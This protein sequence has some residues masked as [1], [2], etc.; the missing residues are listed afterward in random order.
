M[1]REGDVS[2]HGC[3]YKTRART[4]YILVVEMN[5]DVSDHDFDYKTR[6]VTTYDLEVQMSDPN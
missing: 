3:N 6:A 5:G 1:W 2:D 4:T